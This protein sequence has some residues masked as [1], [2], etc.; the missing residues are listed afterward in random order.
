MN[1]VFLILLSNSIDVRSADLLQ[2]FRDFAKINDEAENA[3][4]QQKANS[5]ESK[6]RQIT[7]AEFDEEPS[8]TPDHAQSQPREND[9]VH[10]CLNPSFPFY[11]PAQLKILAVYEGD[12]IKSKDRKM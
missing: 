10:N 11:N 5:D 4:G 9:S 3:R 2:K 7:Q 12:Q 8:R 1:S 6:W